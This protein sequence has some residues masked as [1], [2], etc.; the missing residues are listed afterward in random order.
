MINEVA[1]T[2]SQLNKRVKTILNN[3]PYLGE[4]VVIGEIS[5]FK[6]HSSG[7]IY[8]TLKDESA[9]VR[10]A[11]FK[12]YALYASK[13]LKDGIRVRVTALP[14]L[15]ERDG[16]FQLNVYK[17]EPEGKGDLY[18][19][20]ELL[21]KKLLD[22]GLF[23]EKYK[24]EIPPFVKKIGVVTSPTG[25]VFRDIVNVATRR[26]P[27]IQ[28][29]LAPVAVQG[30]D[31]PRSICTGIKAIDE[32]DDV[33]VI[34]VGRGGGSI[35]DLWCFNDE[36]VARTI[37][38]CSKP[39]ISAVGHETDFTIAD[40][41]ADLRAPTPSAAAELATFDY[42]E[43]VETLNYFERNLCNSIDEIL[44]EYK[45]KIKNY[46]YEF[47]DPQNII[48]NYKHRLDI[49]KIRLF[50]SIDIDEN[51]SKFFSLSSKLDALSPLKVLARG[52]SVVQKENGQIVK[53]ESQVKSGE[54]VNI[55]LDK[56]EIKAEV[57]K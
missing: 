25:A 10:C 2:V 49:L 15:F 26:C 35:E 27:E 30:E 31:A 48:K 37:F 1:I 41:V 11:F 12:P 16:Q 28:I 45:Y 40:F 4:V 50:D 52:Y 17:V 39:I 42:F 51:K 22:E 38:A 54:Q 18:F 55:R 32:I 7:H 43:I 8:F 21:K 19:Q 14:T 33:D 57:I 3:D 34:I 56:G 29:V 9:A 46:S 53:D 23:D 5:G 13:E 6:R 36:T 47:Q 20:F 24:K 44:K